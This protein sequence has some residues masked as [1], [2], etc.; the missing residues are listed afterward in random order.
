MGLRIVHITLAACVLLAGCAGNKV[1]RNPIWVSGKI[2]G[3]QQSVC[4]CGGVETK[5][6]FKK[7]RDAE[8]KAQQ[9]R[10]RVSEG[11]L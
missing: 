7:R 10:Q 6:S 1:A 4:N 3:L 9:M 11:G 8:A 5:K 2:N